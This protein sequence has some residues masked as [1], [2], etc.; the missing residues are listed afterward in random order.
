MPCG[1]DEDRARDIHRYSVTPEPAAMPNP[2]KCLTPAALLI[3]G[4]CATVPSGPSVVVLP[5]TGKN[6][7]QFRADEVVCRQFASYQAGGKMP[8]Q[9]AT[10]SGT[11]SQ[12]DTGRAAT[13]AG[14]AQERYDIGYIQCMYAKGNRVPVP[15]NIMYKDRSSCSPPPPPPPGES[16]GSEGS[17]P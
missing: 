4:A 3:L 10:A 9:N 8:N 2:L 6:F 1:L 5:G 13:S 11:R 16:P 12:A 7:D 17:E 14:T 15:G